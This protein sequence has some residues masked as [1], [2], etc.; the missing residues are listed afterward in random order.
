MP[1]LDIFSSRTVS[2]ILFKHQFLAYFNFCTEFYYFLCSGIDPLP[3]CNKVK[4][5]PLETQC[6]D[7]YTSVA[8]CNLVK[9]TTELPEQYRVSNYILRHR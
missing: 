8:L 3:Y 5:E 6:T 9:Y 1:R 4:A 7:D 2:H